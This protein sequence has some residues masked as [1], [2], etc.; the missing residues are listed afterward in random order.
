MSI[1]QIASDN[2]EKDKLLALREK[3]ADNKERS[4]IKKEKEIKELIKE[5]GHVSN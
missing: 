1:K 5:A 3:A 2:F 4:L